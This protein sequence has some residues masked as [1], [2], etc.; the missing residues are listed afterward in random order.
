MRTLTKGLQ[1]II[2]PQIALQTLQE[3]NNRFV[4]NLRAN[5]NLLQQVNETKDGQHPLAVILSCIDSRTSAELIFD[6]GMG[7]VFSIRIAG[8]ILN[9]DILGSME[10]ACKVVGVKL[11]VVLG[12]TKCGAIKGAVADVKMGNLTQ[13]LAKVK[14]A[15]KAAKKASAHLHLSKDD[16][17]EA[18]AAA[19]VRL[20]AQQISERSPV[21]RGMLEAGEIGIVCGMYSVE[22]GNVA[23]YDNELT[24]P[25]HK[26]AEAI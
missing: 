16:F 14:P 22:S 7:D 21:L 6:Q 1:D 26:M 3:G 8:N 5:R 18:V 9:D 12:H 4:N 2:T 17:I 20:V 24:M 13:L 25:Q 11:V 23:F 10:F 15:V 19:N